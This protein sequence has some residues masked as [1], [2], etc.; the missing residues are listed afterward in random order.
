MRRLVF[1]RQAE[2]EFAA[3]IEWYGRHNP[4]TG[5][6]FAEAAEGLVTAIQRNPYQYQIVEGEVRRA[7]MRDFRYAVVYLVKETELI[8]ISWFHT[9]RDPKIWRDRL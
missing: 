5:I 9:A 1:R 6:R 3:A 4:K 8:I 2:L 7:P